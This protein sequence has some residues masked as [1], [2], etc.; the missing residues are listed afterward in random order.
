MGERI[1]YKNIFS[2][3][4]LPFPPPPPVGGG[5]IGTG[6]FYPFPPDPPSGERGIGEEEAREN[7]ILNP[8]HPSLILPLFVQIITPNSK[9]CFTTSYTFIYMPRLVMLIFIHYLVVCGLLVMVNIM[10]ILLK[11]CYLI[12]FFAP[13]T[14][15]GSSKNNRDG[16][17]NN[18]IPSTRNDSNN[19]ASYTCTCIIKNIIR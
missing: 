2:K 10:M 8:S 6:C 9:K 13:H 12:F 3:S 16:S 15:V 17:Y 19:T 1:N 4:P 11:Q 18:N 5:G 7:N 14:S